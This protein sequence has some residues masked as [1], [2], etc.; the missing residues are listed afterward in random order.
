M[1]FQFGE[2]TAISSDTGTVCIIAI[3]L[4][5]VLFEYVTDAVELLE[6][7]SPATYHMIQKVFK[8]LMI[9]GLVSFLIVMFETTKY[10]SSASAVV[11]AVD[12]CH[13]LL[14]FVALYFILHAFLLIRLSAYLSLQ[15]E[16]IHFTNI[17]TILEEYNEIKNKSCFN[18]E[19]FRWSSTSRKIEFKVMSH[20]FRECFLLPPQF[21]FSDYLSGC[22]QKYAL[23]LLNIGPTTWGFVIILAVVNF[24]RVKMMEASDLL[25][26]AAVE[27]SSSNSTASTTTTHRRLSG[28][29]VFVITPE[30]A[31][32]SVKVFLCAGCILVCLVLILFF[33]SRVY[34]L[35]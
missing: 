10:A 23:Q 20:F 28:S 25:C 17:K 29:A 7:G 21:G 32:S 26:K 35:R 27:S 11:L 31:D 3:V 4:F 15:Y 9:M 8:E 14:F 33:F 22:F 6:E 19:Y 13:I 16:N 1:G 34:E 30:C 18:T 12:Y 24:A 2:V 5:L